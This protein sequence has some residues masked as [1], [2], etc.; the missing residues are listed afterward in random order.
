[1]SQVTATF[2]RIFKELLRDKVLLFW[3]VFFPII[4]LLMANFIFMANAL[5]SEEASGKGFFT[6][7]MVVYAIM[8]AGMVDIPAYIAHDR[9]R[10]MLTKLKSMPV[11]QTKDFIGRLMAFLAFSLMA[12]VA[13]LLIG[14]LLGA[15]FSA[16]PTSLAQSVGFLFLPILAASGI[17]LIIGTLIS[18]EQ[19]A[20]Y[21]G[22]GIA[23]ITAFISGIFN[24]YRNLPGVLQ[25]FSRIYP[26]SSSNYSLVYLLIG[27]K[28]AGYNPLELSQMGLTITS[29]VAL[30][31]AGLAIYTKFSWR[32]E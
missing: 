21:S 12:I 14:M 11:S 10:G 3:S 20:V 15:R 18:S 2:V 5:P 7:S 13:V 30:F 4:Y 8:I 25:V 22:I 1:M 24:L 31:G 17:G 6:L 28:M 16:S 32:K 26:I 23:L 27:E 29:S 9:A 19:G